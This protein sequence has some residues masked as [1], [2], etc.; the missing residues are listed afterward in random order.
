[1]TDRDA[2]HGP[3]NELR[4]PWRR[5]RSGGRRAERWAGAVAGQCAEPLSPEEAVVAGDL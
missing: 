1:V 3:W 2:R 5:Q 4:L